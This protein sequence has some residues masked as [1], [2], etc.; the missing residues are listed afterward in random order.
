MPDIHGAA[1]E[2]NDGA[3]MIEMKVGLPYIV[4]RASD[5]GTFQ[6]GDHIYLIDNGDIACHE[7]EGWI[8]REDVPESTIGME[9]ELDQELIEKRRKTLL[10][11]LAALGGA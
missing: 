5:D 3:S 1:I 6:V 10:A 4:T 2:T 7:A 8:D 11:V 9:I